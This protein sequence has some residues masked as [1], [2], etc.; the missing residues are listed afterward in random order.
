MTSHGQR[1]AAVWRVT[2]GYCWY[3][4]CDLKEHGMTIDHLRP[5]SDG[6]TNHLPN[7]VPACQSCNQAKGSDDLETY[8]HKQE[9]KTFYGERARVKQA[10]AS[11]PIQHLDDWRCQACGRL[12]ARVS[13][14]AGTQVHIETVCPKCGHTNVRQ[15]RA[16]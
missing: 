3:C 7:L 9:R 1:R 13:C 5:K 10:V 4:G 15:E 11:A 8:R 12:L 14:P 16:A 2:G 6:G